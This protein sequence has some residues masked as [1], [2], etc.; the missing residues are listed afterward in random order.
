M[1]RIKVVIVGAGFGGLTA[2]ALLARDGWEVLVLEKNEEIGGR[3]RIWKE[4]GFIFDMG[5]T[6]YLMPEVFEDYFNL[7]GKKP[8]DY[9]SLQK[10][11]L[12]YRIFFTD[13]QKV[14]I[15]PN[16]EETVETFEKFE[17]GGGAKIRK[18]LEEA[19]YKYD[20][21][22]KEFIY[23]DYSRI[24]KLINKR[25][26]VH[27]VQLKV[28]RSLDGLVKKHFSDHHAKKILEYPMV[29]LGNSPWNAPALYSIMSHVDLNQG[30]WYPHGGMGSV[31]DALRQ[32]GQSQ[33]V[34][35]ETSKNVTKLVIRNG[36]V[37]RVVTSDDEYASDIVLMNADYAFAERELLAPAYQSFDDRY[38]KKKVFAPSMFMI[39]L[40]LNKKLNALSHHNFHFAH[41]WEKH[42][43]TIFNT[44]SW[45]DN[46]S[47]YVHCPTKTDS[48]VAPE[49][50]ENMFILIP[51]AIGLNDSEAQR[52]KFSERIMNH[53]ERLIG[54]DIRDSVVLQRIFSHRDYEKAYHA[55][56]GTSS[57]LAHTLLQT[58]VFRPSC[59]SRKVKNLYYTGHYTH[60]GIGVPM[61]FISSRLVSERIYRE[62]PR[63]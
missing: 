23:R 37:E 18:Y 17:T 44:P 57:G 30:V 9:Y 13:G 8:E 19:A 16:L 2:A 62:W 55:Y 26:L 15:T 5:P 49:D 50:Q 59:R 34:Q 27:G 25:L 47:Y 20:I 48:T 31:V 41:Q 46:P 6:W 53:L 3:A 54:E 11:D 58:A 7:F 35:I 42:F 22:M 14:D 12:S 10:L 60:P 32:L 63:K 33:G 24:S 28:F 36:K 56:Q 38:W 1:K 21:V 4:Q 52:N 43:A 29:F 61:A 51:V 45:P 40:G 39:Y